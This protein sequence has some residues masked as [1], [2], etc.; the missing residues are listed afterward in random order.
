MKPVGLENVFD[1]YLKTKK[2]T[3]NK[4]PVSFNLNQLQTLCLPPNLVKTQIRIMDLIP[5][6]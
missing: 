3:H 5:G 4:K 1:V 6:V 2:V